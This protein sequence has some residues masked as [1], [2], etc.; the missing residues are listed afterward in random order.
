M[1][2]HGNFSQFTTLV[3][4]SAIALAFVACDAGIE[5]S[6]PN[7]QEDEILGSV[8]DD[9]PLGITLAAVKPSQGTTLQFIDVGDGDIAVLEARTKGS[10]S[11]LNQMVMESDATPLEMYV[12]AGGGDSFVLTTLE[13]HHHSVREGAPRDLAIRVVPSQSNDDV[14]LDG[15]HD[16]GYGCQGNTWDAT[17]DNALDPVSLVNDSA[18]FTQED[19]ASYFYFYPGSNYNTKTWLGVCAAPQ[20]NDDSDEKVFQV[21]KKISGTW[22]YV[23]QVILEPNDPDPD[24]DANEYTFYNS[25]LAGS[26]YRGRVSQYQTPSGVAG[27]WG[28]AVAYTYSI[29]GG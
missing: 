1:N 29:I 18:F 13:E 10:R 17:W 3:G 28:V 12:A 7:E 21:Q 16:I 4:L 27:S 14:E 2:N 5:S 9:A 19:I 24:Y 15:E 20:G 11:V 22:T 26:L 6:M 8:T 23:I 25:S